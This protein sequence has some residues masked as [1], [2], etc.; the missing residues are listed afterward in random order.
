MCGITDIRGVVDYISKAI[1]RVSPKIL[2]KNVRVLTCGATYNPNRDVG[3]SRILP[4]NSRL[5]H[6]RC[7]HIGRLRKCK[8][9]RYETFKPY[10]REILSISGIVHIRRILENREGYQ[11]VIIIL[12]TEH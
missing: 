12:H 9:H 4:I 7:Q 8:T 1:Y 11:K 5:L 10:I 3:L 2:R 6:H